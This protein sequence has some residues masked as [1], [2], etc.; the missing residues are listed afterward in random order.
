M[1][2]FMAKMNLIEKAK[3]GIGVNDRTALPP[4]CGVTDKEQSA[5][6]V[7]LEFSRTR[8]THRSFCRISMRRNSLLSA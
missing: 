6:L 5:E 2:W 4:L 1:D 3:N 8:S 7:A